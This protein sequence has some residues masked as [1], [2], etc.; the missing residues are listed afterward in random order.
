MAVLQRDQTLHVSDIFR[1]QAESGIYPVFRDVHQFTAGQLQNAR[2]G[3]Q[4]RPYAIQFW[5][6]RIDEGS[7]ET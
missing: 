5:P 7:V 1:L 6:Q 3:A 4:H 2:T